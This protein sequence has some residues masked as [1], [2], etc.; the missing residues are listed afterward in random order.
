MDHTTDKLAGYVAS[1]SYAD[2]TPTAIHATKR[3]LIDALGCAIGGYHSTPSHIARRIASQVVGIPPARLWGS[4]HPT[5]IELATFA[6]SVMVRYLDYN[7]TYT[8]LGEGHPSDMIPAVLAVG[9]AFHVGGKD[10]LL[11]VVAAYELF[12]ALADVVSLRPKRWDHGYFVVFGSAAGSGKLLRLTKEQMGNALAIASAPN[13]PTRQT[14]SGELSMWKGCATAASAMAGVFAAM[15]AREGLTGPTEAFEGRH[16][17]QEQV[18][19]PFE[20][21]PL[22][23]NGQTFGVERTTIKIFPTENHSQVP[24][25]LILKLRRK[26]SPEDIDRIT[27]ETYHR[28]YSEIGSEPQKWDPKTRETADHSLPYMLAAALR[29]GSVTIDT[30]NQENI[31]DQSLRPLMNRIRVIENPAFTCQFPDIM[32]TKIEVMT[33][34]GQRYEETGSMHARGRILNP[35][36]DDQVEEKFRTL[37]NRSFTEEQLQAILNA[38]WSLEDIQDVSSITALMTMTT[39]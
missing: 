10:L 13:V 2:L 1:L 31:L 7:D 22:G 17:V 39:N 11:S 27:V 6:N 19:G 26:I 24:L 34:T 23:A 12:T 29:D 33:K 25:K 15:L 8:S 18:T 32:T 3:L 14:R 16:G 9:E 36:T 21:L 20:L 5:S 28:A 35:M 37:C 38:I 4:G 30:F